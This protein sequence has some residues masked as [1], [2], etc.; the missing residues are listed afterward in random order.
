MGP[1]EPLGQVLVQDLQD[2][3]ALSRSRDPRH[4]GQKAER[5][6]GRDPFEIVLGRGLDGQ[7]L[8]GGAVAL[9]KG[10]RPLAGEILPRQGPLRARDLLRGSAG[11]DLATAGARPGPHVDHVV[12]GADRLLVVLHHQ[13]G[14]AQVAQPDQGVQQTAVVPLVQ[15]DAGLV[16]DIQY[17]RKTGPDLGGQ[18]NALAFAAGQRRGRPVQCQVIHTHIHE[19]TQ[20][21]PDLLEDALGDELLALAESHRGE[22][23]MGIAHRHAG[24]VGDRPAGHL[25]GQTLRLETVAATGRAGMKAHVLLHVLPQIAGRRLVIPAAQH[26]DHP[27][28]GLFVKMPAAL[29]FIK[30][31]DLLLARPVQQQPLVLGPEL[32]E[33]LG[34][35]E[36]AMPGH[37][38]QRLVM[39]QRVALFPRADGPLPQRTA[40]VRDDQGG[41]EILSRAQAVA[42]GAGAVR[43]VE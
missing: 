43:A 28:E 19:E 36:S 33:G 16:Q 4:A 13:D 39:V 38:L 15:P 18:T 21:L 40:W 29:L 14:V 30:E 6:P 32:A 25:H 24:H 27:L 12:G 37:R 3:R 31:G 23:L 22:K 41:I 8:F 9:R 42:L 20:P 26:R 1:I 11:D 10:N 5:D 35:L 34:E 2:Q 17:A 7:V